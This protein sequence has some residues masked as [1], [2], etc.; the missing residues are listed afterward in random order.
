MALVSIELFQALRTA[1]LSDNAALEVAERFTP[2]SSHVLDVLW[3]LKAVKG[4]TVVCMGLTA[5]LLVTAF[6]H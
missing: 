6:W 4:M 1:G 2:Q 3:R 5:V